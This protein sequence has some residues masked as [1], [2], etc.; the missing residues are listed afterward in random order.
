MNA[1]FYTAE[2]VQSLRPTVEEQETMRVF[3]LQEQPN[4]GWYIGSVLGAQKY[5]IS[6]DA[7]AEYLGIL[8]RVMNGEIINED[9]EY[10]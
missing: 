1:G 7:T 5:A 3:F 9:G 10:I 2:Q 8:G 6:Q 4:A